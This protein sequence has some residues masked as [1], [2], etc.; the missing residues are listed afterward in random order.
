[1]CT[2]GVRRR[3]AGPGSAGRPFQPGGLLLCAEL[4]GVTAPLVGGDLLQNLELRK[5]GTGYS[6]TLSVLR[7][8]R[9]V[10]YRF[11]RAVVEPGKPSF[12][13]SPVRGVS[14]RFEGWLTRGGDLARGAARRGEDIVE[15]VLE[16]TVTKLSGGQERGAAEL[17]FDLLLAAERKYGATSCCS[18]LKQRKALSAL[19]LA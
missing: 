7:G 5:A 1:M 14:Y 15:G 4:A 17:K 16:G 9:M 3:H 11:A 19:P 6:G 18:A 12:T 2:G 13:T 8:N 10:T